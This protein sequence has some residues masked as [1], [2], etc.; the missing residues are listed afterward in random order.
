MDTT[1]LYY[2]KTAL[3]V[4][5]VTFILYKVLMVAQGTKA[6]QILK[7]ICGIVAFWVISGLLGLESV[8][9]LLTQV[10]TYGIFGVFV[11]FQPELRT[12]LENLGKK[13]LFGINYQQN[14]RSAVKDN[15]ITSL[16]KASEYLSERH[17]GALIN[18][19]RKDNLQ[20]YID[21][22]IELDA[23]ITKE[24]L[25]NIFT[26]NVPLHDG[27][28]IIRKDRIIAAS[29]YLPLSQSRTIPKELGTRH[30]AGIGLGEVTDAFTL[31]VSEETGAISAVIEG[32]LHRDISPSALRNLLEQ[33]LKH[34]EEDETVKKSF[35]QKLR[36]KRKDKDFMENE[37]AG[38]EGGRQ[39]E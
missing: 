12:A 23:K 32:D 21:T 38:K 3:D 17:I 27:A 1:V 20:A 31:I 33:Y 2:I 22:G 36:G 13:G 9:F 37:V 11:I 16:V 34:Q 30:R 28:L 25:E 39:D 26:P 15:T 6:M 24:L 14:D 5:I 29:C 4:G 18:I 7:A 8:K 10:F 35:F 19:E